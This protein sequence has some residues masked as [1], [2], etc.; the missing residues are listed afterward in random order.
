LCDIPH[1]STCVPNTGDG[2]LALLL[3][4]NM[5]VWILGPEIDE[6]PYFVSLPFQSA[7]P[8]VRPQNHFSHPL[9]FFIYSFHCLMLFSLKYRQWFQ[10]NYELSK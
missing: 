8:P 1:V 2:W 9:Q 6:F 5:M 3:L 4:W 7:V 10:I